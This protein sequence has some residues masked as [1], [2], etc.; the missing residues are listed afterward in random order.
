MESEKCK[1]PSWNEYFLNIAKIVGSRGTF[2]RGQ[3]GCV[4]TNDKRI[5]STGYAGSPV[6]LPHCDDVGH[7]MHTVVH[8]DGH[9]S[10]HCIRTTHAEQNAIVQAARFGAALLGATLYCKAT[11]C[12]SCA[13][14]II[15]AG[16]K[17]VVCEQDYHAGERS[18][19]IFKEA[20]IQYELVNDVMTEYEDMGGAT[21]K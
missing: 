8:E 15:N 12:Y 19:E 7:E 1:R 13:K 9:D 16:I 6:G 21:K 2:D 4:I 17:R 5:I 18:K 20:G 10:R 3:I 14:M 11:P